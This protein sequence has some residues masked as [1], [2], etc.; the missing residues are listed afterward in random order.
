MTRKGST[1]TC[2]VVGPAGAQQS[3]SGNS[4]LVPRNDTGLDVWAFGMTAV[5]NSLQI[6]GPP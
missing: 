6:I 3:A 1:Y 2:S 5:F 4:N